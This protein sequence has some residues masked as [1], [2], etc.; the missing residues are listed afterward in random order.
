MP[1]DPVEEAA[2]RL[3]G[4]PLEQF[5]RE[6]DARA[7]ALRKAGEKDVAAAVAKLP[8]PSQV[9]WVANQLGR[10]GA[11][12][13]LAAGEAMREAQ[14]GGGGREALRKATA[15][16][17]AAVDELMRAADEHR[18]LSRDGRDR[19]RALLHALASD[20][21]LREQFAAGRIVEEPEAGGAWP[22]G[23]FTAPAPAERK[24]EPAKRK[25][26]ESEAEKRK[27]EERE[28]KA[29][30]RARREAERRREEAE[31]R[32]LERRLEAAREAAD[33]ARVRLDAAREAYE[34]ATHEVARIEEQL[35]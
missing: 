21:E 26:S 17:R 3:Y 5:V 10:A 12:D 30:E 34:R 23:A 33:D 16:E 20:E 15:A 18:K 22:S 27:R 29:A 25:K 28:R 7:K 2:D 8:K 31:R 11:G 19:L 1:A 32:R 13:L 4:L 6:R 35:S 14:L 24:A 9:A